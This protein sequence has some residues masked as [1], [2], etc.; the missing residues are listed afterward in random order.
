SWYGLMVN[1][2]NL[3]ISV[4]S[5]LSIIFLSGCDFLTA[6]MS[7]IGTVTEW[8]RAINHVYLITTIVCALV[9]IIVAGLMVYVIWRFR[10]RPGDTHIPKQ[11]HGNYKLE[12][13]WSV[14]PCILLMFIV[15]PT[16][17]VIFK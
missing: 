8:G 12:I 16:W 3:P 4:L 2:V 14:I 13:L 9:G 17:E 7:T 11:V 1:R 15:I 6:P 10:E 5:L